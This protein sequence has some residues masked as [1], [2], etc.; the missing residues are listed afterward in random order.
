VEEEEVSEYETDSEYEDDTNP[1]MKIVPVF[2]RRYDSCISF[3]LFTHSFTCRE[4]R[5]TIAERDKQDEEYEKQQELL[6]QQAEERKK[7][8]KRMVEEEKVKEK[9]EAENAEAGK[10]LSFSVG[11]CTN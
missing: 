7:E 5:E 3:K 4:N 8:S 10:F 6:R 1:S 9:E 11:T 2:V